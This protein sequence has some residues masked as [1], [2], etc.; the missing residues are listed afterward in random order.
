M[1]GV[2]CVDDHFVPYA[3]ARPVGKGWDTKHRRVARGRADTHAA[4]AR[5]RALVFTTGEASALT[6]TLP[7]ALAELRAV[8]GPD[9]R[10]LLGFDRGGA[11]PS[12]FAACRDAGA[13][14]VTYRRAPLV[15][16]T[17]LPLAA[18]LRTA[19]PATGY[20]DEPVEID[21]YGTSSRRS[22]QHHPESPAT[23]ARSPTPS[24]PAEAIKP[25]RRP[26]C[27]RSGVAPAYVPRAE[28]ESGCALSR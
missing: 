7:P 25:P 10:I 20:A 6:K 23:H 5:G 9:A 13:D 22:T 19:G 3:V 11:Y 12:V 17:R 4:D 8:T 26:H 24:P 28:P 16:P 14:W 15:A 1:G 21:G 18:G 2:Y 27:R